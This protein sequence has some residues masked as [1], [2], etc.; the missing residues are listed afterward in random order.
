MR[1][2]A[3]GLGPTIGTLQG[4]GYRPFQPFFGIL[5]GT[6]LQ[7]HNPLHAPG[8]VMLPSPLRPERKLRPFP[9]LLPETFSTS[10]P[11]VTPVSGISVQHY[12]LAL[13]KENCDV[14]EKL[15]KPFD[16]VDFS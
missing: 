15:K 11:N 7:R 6:P 9:K 13:C 1:F 16:T 4:S 2:Q 8:L 14:Q 3:F 12:T 10:G 5:F